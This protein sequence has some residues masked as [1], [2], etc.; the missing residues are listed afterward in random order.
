[1]CSLDHL[2]LRTHR[3]GHFKAQIMPICVSQSVYAN[4]RLPF[5]PFPPW[6]YT[7]CTGAWSVV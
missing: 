1:M 4:V 7:I 5:Q 2:S 6:A 3:A